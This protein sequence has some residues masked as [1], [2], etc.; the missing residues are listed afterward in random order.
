MAALAMARR[1]KAIDR[2]G[3]GAHEERLVPR[4]AGSAARSVEATRPP[5]DVTRMKGF[6]VEYCHINDEFVA[7]IKDT[8]FMEAAK[9]MDK[10]I[11]K[12][13]RLV[14]RGVRIS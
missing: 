11:E 13:N 3:P 7:T 5:D 10:A 2:S 9:S 6:R 12:L 14:R 4:I 1:H 8:D